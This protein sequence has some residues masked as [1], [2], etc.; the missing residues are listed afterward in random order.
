MDKAAVVDDDDT[1]MMIES[2]TPNPWKL[3]SVT[4]VEEVKMM[5]RLL[6]IWATTIM[7]YV[8]HAQMITFAVLQASTMKRSIGTFSIPPGSFNAFFIGAIMLA[9]GVYDRLIFA[10]WKRKNGTLGLTNLQKIGLGLFTSILAM[11]V[12]AIVETKRLKVAKSTSSS[13]ISILTMSAFWLVPQFVLAGV[14]EGFV[15]TG[16]ID[17]FLVESP[18]GMKA[19]STSLFLTTIAFGFFVS[20]ALVSIVRRVTEA[21]GHNWLPANINHGRLNLFYGV[22]ALLSF[23]NLGFY[24]CSAKWFLQK[25]RQTR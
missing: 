14:A 12:A 15:Y 6:P 16:Q 25:K 18:K 9:L 13:T 23:I 5:T 4:K 11:V 17:F 24:L 21:G 8:I 3:C 20:S 2:G 1:N 19:I 10:L 7:Y 22:V